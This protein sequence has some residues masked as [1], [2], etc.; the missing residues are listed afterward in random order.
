[1]QTKSK[2]EIAQDVEETRVEAK[3]ALRNVGDVWKGKNAIAS[4]WRSTKGGYFR[5]QEMVVD[6]V[7]TTD[8]KLRSN[9]YKSLG[10]TIGIGA[11]LGFFLTNRPRLRKRRHY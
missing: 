6:A 8:D 11:I 10:I 2:E 9:I 4:A 3:R 5:A 7:E 1:M